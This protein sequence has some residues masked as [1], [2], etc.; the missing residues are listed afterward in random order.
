[1]TDH[2]VHPHHEETDA[3]V[4]AV[5]LS[6]VA[7]T[8]LVTVVFVVVWGLY[9][10]V[11]AQDQA[12]D[13]R[14]S[15]IPSVSP[16]PPEPRLQTDPAEDFQVYKSEQERILNSYEWTSRNEGRVRIP[17]QRAMDLVAERGLPAVS[18]NAEKKK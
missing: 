11:R 7:L 12:R 14:R 15:L 2:P 1:M 9:R 3:N 8:V 6:F 4:R 13:V 5:T 18:A 17:I 16:I 10:F